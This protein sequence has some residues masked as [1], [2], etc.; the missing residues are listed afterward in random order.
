MYVIAKLEFKN[1]NHST[2][3]KMVRMM[4]ERHGRI[5]FGLN[6]SLWRFQL[7]KLSAKEAAP[8]SWFDLIT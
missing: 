6:Y 3:I 7:S 2:Q 4:L 8:I 1:G 5:A